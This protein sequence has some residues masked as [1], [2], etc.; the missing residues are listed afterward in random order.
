MRTAFHPEQIK[1]KLDNVGSATVSDFEK[2]RID[3]FEQYI[4]THD[5]KVINEDIREQKFHNIIERNQPQL[6]YET[7]TKEGMHA[8]DLEPLTVTMNID[9]KGNEDEATEPPEEMPD[10]TNIINNTSVESDIRDDN[11]E[12][13]TNPRDPANIMKHK[14][15]NGKSARD[16]GKRKSPK[17]TKSGKY[18]KKKDKVDDDLEHGD[19]SIE[20]YKTGKAVKNSGSN[21]FTKTKIP[22]GYKTKNPK[23][24]L[25]PESVEN[26]KGDEKGVKEST[27]TK[28]PYDHSALSSSPTTVP[29]TGDDEGKYNT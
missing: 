11:Q 2:S 26:S 20:K 29:R 14:F 10:E 24:T 1:R 25:S 5:Y 6:V 27:S 17:G 9:V 12:P 8:V 7:T 3:Q 16:P 28:K 4:H 21:S 18:D 15:P 23:H 13:S 19:N 22:K